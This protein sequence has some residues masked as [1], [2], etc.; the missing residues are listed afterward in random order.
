MVNFIFRLLIIKL[1]YIFRFIVREV[2]GV[3]S[4]REEVG[5]VRGIIGK[6]EG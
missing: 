2:L 5:F 3:I 4:G 1:F 6:W